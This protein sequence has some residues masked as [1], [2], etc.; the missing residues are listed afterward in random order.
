MEIERKW[1][2]DRSRI[3]YDLTALPSL[4]LEQVYVSFIPSVRVRSMR[5]KDGSEKYV[6]TVKS[7]AKD[8]GKLSREEFEIPI[9]GTAYA[10]LAAKGEGTPIEKTRYFV[11]RED[12]L[13]E[14]IDLFHGELEGLAYLEIEFD[15]I[16]RA[17]AFPSP[18]WTT[19]DVTAE[20]RF[21]NSALAQFG[22]PEGV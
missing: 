9:D 16:E 3:P 21:R 18:A 15:S 14:E 20:K 4:E 22:K 7:S 10:S 8:E 12:G 11:H 1:L 19:R 6:L 2:V 5:A 17:E 13:V